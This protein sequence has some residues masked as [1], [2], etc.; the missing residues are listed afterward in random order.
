VGVWHAALS[1]RAITQAHHCGLRV[2]AY[3]VDDPA[4]ADEL[5]GWGL[6]TLVTDAVDRIAP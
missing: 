1:E 6:D 4:R 3:T 5:F 2:L